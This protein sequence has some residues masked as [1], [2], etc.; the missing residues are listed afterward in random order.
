[1]LNSYEFV[2]SGIREGALNESIYKRMQYGV[3]IRDWK[4]MK[5]FVEQLRQA[6]DHGTLF[7]EFERLGES[8]CADPLKHYK[9]KKWYW[10]S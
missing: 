4:A 3:V 2:A 7:Q 8:W 10:F 9:Q 6:R 1:M 5:P